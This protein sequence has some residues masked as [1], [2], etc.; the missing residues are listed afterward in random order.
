MAQTGSGDCDGR[1]VTGAPVAADRRPSA[2]S[3]GRRPVYTFFFPQ[4]EYKPEYLDP[5]AKF[6]QDGIGDVDIHIHHNCEGEEKFLDKMCGFIEVLTK[7]HGLLRQHEGK[8]VFGF[9]HGN[10]ALDNSRPDG[11][12]CGLNNEIT[13]LRDLGCYADFTMPSGA[14]PTQ[15]RVVNQIYWVND[16]PDKPRSYDRGT[17]VRTGQPGQGDLL[18]ITGP[19]GLRWRERFVPR[20]ETGEIAWQD[21]PTPYHISRWLDLAPRI[22][23][24]IFVKLYTHGAQERNSSA[25]LEKGGLNDLFRMLGEVCGARGYRWYSVSAWQMRR[26][27]DKASRRMDPTTI[28]GEA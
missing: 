19:M 10:W 25:L 3:A 27:V 13:L 26:A 21:F 15:G 17:E 11:T 28:F 22:G 12:W 2:D 23:Q 5:L 6:T 9:I 8:T 1:E 16:D 7:G 24:E 4:E 18:M 14:S 20:L